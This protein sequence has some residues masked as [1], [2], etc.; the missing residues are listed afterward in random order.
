MHLVCL[1]R[2]RE[3]DAAVNFKVVPWLSCA[4]P[5]S[6]QMVRVL[7]RFENAVI[8]YHAQMF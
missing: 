1:Q 3:P 8:P 5:P 2:N 7:Q 6:D 4:L